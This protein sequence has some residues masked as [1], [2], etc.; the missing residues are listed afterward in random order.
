MISVLVSRKAKINMESRT[1]GRIA[2]IEACRFNHPEVV[3]K[4]LTFNETSVNVETKSEMAM[5]LTPLVAVA[6]YNS[7][8]CVEP[9]MKSL[10]R[11]QEIEMV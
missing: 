7:I 6:Y 9:I 11:L 8:D 1:G 10:T 4:L 2:L 3:K 5:H